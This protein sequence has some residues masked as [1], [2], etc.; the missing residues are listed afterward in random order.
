MLSKHY[1]P[2]HSEKE[3][4]EMW[5]SKGI[6]AFSQEG[7]GEIYSID[8]PPPTVSGNLHLGHIYSYSQTDFIARFWRMRGKNVF[9]PMGFDDNGLPTERLT[10][11]RLKVRP[12]EI[13]RQEFIKLCLKVSEESEQDYMAL[14]KRLGL[15]VDWRYTYRTIDDH[16]RR[17]SQL[18]FIDLYR[19]SLVYHQEAPA[20]WCPECHTS[21]AQAELNDMER[22]SE[23]VTLDFRLPDGSSLP[24]ATTRPELLPAC[25]AVFV[26]PNDSRYTRLVGQKVSVPLFHQE[27]PILTD[28][29]ADPEKGTG[30]VMC[31][32]FGDQMDVTWWRTHKLNL[33]QAINREG[34]M[35]DVAGKF[36]G[37]PLEDARKDIKRELD[38]TGLILGRQPTSQ[39]IR[40]HER[41]DTPVEYIMVGQWFIR[42]LDFKSQLLQAGELVAWW[43]EHMLARYRAWVEGLNW[44]W[45]I[46]RQRYFGVPIPLW[47]CLDCG[48]VVLADEFHLPVDPVDDAP[49]NPCPKCGGAHFRPET[50]VMD[51]WAT[52]SMSPQIAGGWL[53]EESTLYQ[54]VFPFTLRSQAHEIIRT[55]AFYTIAK[56]IYH[57]NRL[58]W[59]NVAISGWGIAGEGM[60]KISKSRGGGPV[61]PMEMIERYSADAVR[62]WAASTGPGKDAV[63]SEE[64]IQS[65]AALVTKIWNVARFCERFL[66]EYAPADDISQ[67][68]LAPADRWILA[69]LQHLI[70]RSTS[71]FEQYDY[72]AAKNE[73]EQFFWRELADNYLEMVKQRLYG[74]QSE[75]RK[76]TIWTL[77]RVLLTVTKL[78][79]PF[80]PYV[81]ET[82]YSEIF[83]QSE[84]QDS[85]HL[86]TWPEPEPKLVNEVSEA[87]GETLVELATQVR[88]HKSQQSISLGAEIEKI[89]IIVRD[90]HTCT[91]LQ[92]AMSDLKSITRAI[93]I[94]FNV[95]SGYASESSHPAYVRF[96]AGYLS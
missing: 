28:S 12:A 76:A 82:I 23:F 20:I 62:Y 44:D 31:C 15:S 58:P 36:V 17:I 74:E 4:Q 96:D 89:T 65:G 8:T 33:I 64:K 7:K 93:Q 49:S 68:A 18:S 9:Y 86:S 43:P 29:N 26:H 3:L 13:N 69:K 80:L 46:S 73:V 48:E 77:Y 53:Q 2:K 35:T 30:A 71:L 59:Q 88:R 79:A 84:G 90:E 52:S 45:C 34:R 41:C 27:V 37:L 50:D 72:A 6:Y 38:E 57:F 47:F 32:T 92:A 55:W 16:S 5:Q 22:Q 85:I 11:K 91:A 94:E 56:S 40:V 66:T 54:K 83:A 24:I 95:E 75:T 67:L 60:G 70:E 25:V 61:A 14:W 19:K 39:S 51:T 10:E 63:I 87:L 81:T 42:V 1:D 78:F 21:I